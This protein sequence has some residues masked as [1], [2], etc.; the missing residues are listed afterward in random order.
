[1]RITSHCIS[2]PLRVNFAS[3]ASSP[4]NKVSMQGLSGELVYRNQH[5]SSYL[6]L[7][8]ACGGN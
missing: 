4:N 1:M 8:I 3:W 7:S 2:E 6:F 5:G